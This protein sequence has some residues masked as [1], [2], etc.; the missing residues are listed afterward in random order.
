MNNLG[1]IGMGN[2]AQAL[3]AGF[4][5][6]GAIHKENVFAFAPNQEKLAKNAARIGFTPMASIAEL[7]EK[8]DTL[9]MACKPYQIE[10]V[11]AELGTALNGK[12][13]ISIAAGWDFAKYQTVLKTNTPLQFVMPNTPAMVGEGVL[14]FEEKNTLSPEEREQVMKLFAAVG[15]VQELPSNLMGI[16]GTVTGCGPAFVDLFIEAYGDAAVKYGLKREDAYRLISQMVLGSAK[17]Q[18][19]TGTH[20]GVLKDNVCSPAGTTIRGVTA[21][22]EQGFRN[23]CIKSVD[24]IMNK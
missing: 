14:L 16:G 20:P 21:L 1:F 5:E 22:E 6:A 11:L 3:A 15:L 10:S 12:N 2:M 9:V 24:A 4:I 19:S 17:L 8:C 23:A 18:L 13:L 7:A